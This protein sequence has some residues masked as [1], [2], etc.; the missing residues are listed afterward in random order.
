MDLAEKVIEREAKKA[1]FRGKINAKCCECIYDPY[2]A[3]TWREQVEKCSS[4]AC[5]LYEI[6]PL[7]KKSG[8]DS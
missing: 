1:G 7:P 8:D 3:G 4:L 2:A 5:P 6:R